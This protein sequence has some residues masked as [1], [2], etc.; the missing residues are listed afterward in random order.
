MRSRGSSS[1]PQGREKTPVPAARNH[2]QVGPGTWSA[3]R[4]RPED[5]AVRLRD[6]ASLLVLAETLEGKLAPPPADLDDEGPADAASSAR[7]LA[8]RLPGRPPALAVRRGGDVHVP[9][10]SAW[11]DVAQRVRILHALANHEL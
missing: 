5:R 10:P 1:V 2:L 8:M 7:A 11:A 3:G 4:S 6:F 9:P